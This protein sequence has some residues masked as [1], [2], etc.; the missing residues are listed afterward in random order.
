MVCPRSWTWWLTV[1]PSVYILRAIHEPVLRS[2]VSLATSSLRPS[3]LT[4]QATLQLIRQT[5]EAVLRPSKT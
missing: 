4:Q 1:R 3:T 2:R 5:A